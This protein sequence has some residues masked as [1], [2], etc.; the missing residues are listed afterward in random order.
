MRNLYKYIITLVAIL[1]MATPH[2]WAAATCHTVTKS[3]F[4]TTGE[5]ITTSKNW[6]GR[7]EK[8]YFYYFSPADQESFTINNDFGTI[9]NISFTATGD[10]KDD[11]LTF[12]VIYQ[13]ANNSTWTEIDNEIP[14][15]RYYDWGGWKASSTNISLSTS[16]Y[17]GLKD[18]TT[19]GIRFTKFNSS[20]NTEEEDEKR[21]IT[22]SNVSVTFSNYFHS[23]ANNT[24]LE[25][26][27][28]TEKGTTCTTTR[29]FT[30]KYNN[31]VTSVNWTS[32]NSM[33]TVSSSHEED[34]SGEKTV[35]ITFKPTEIRSEITGTITGTD[36]NGNKITVYVKGSSW[37]K[38]DPTY[39]WKPEIWDGTSQVR[40]IY[41][42]ET[43]NDMLNYTSSPADCT[44]TIEKLQDDG[45]NNGDATTTFTDNTLVAGR[46]GKYKLTVR[47]PAHSISATSGYNAGETTI[48]LTISK[49]E[50]S[51]DWALADTYWVDDQITEESIITNKT[52]N[53]VA[54]SVSDSQGFFTYSDNTLKANGNLMPSGESH[55]TTITVTQEE[56]YK[57]TKQTLTKQITLKRHTISAKINQTTAVWNEL[58]NNPFSASSTHP[59]SGQVTPIDD[60]TVT[61]QGNEHIALMD[62]NSRNIQTYYTNGTVYFLITHPEDY[63]YNALSQTLTLHV[64]QSEETCDLITDETA[65][66][67]HSTGQ[68]SNG[69]YSKIFTLNGI[70]DKLIFKY[71]LNGRA[72]YNHYVTP[73]YSTTDTG[74]N[75]N[76]ITTRFT[77]QSTTPTSS[78]SIT[79]PVGTKRIRF[80]RTAA[81]LGTKKV[82]LSNITVTRA[83]YIRPTEGERALSSTDT[84]KLP[85][86]AIGQPSSQQF[87]LKWSA[88]SD[89]KIVC[90]NPKFT[91]GT[92]DI[93]SANGNQ[94]IS[95]A[96]NTSEVGTFLGNITIYNQEQMETFPISC[97]V[98][99]KWLTDSIRGS[100]AYSMKVD[101]T[102][103]TD[104]Y[105]PVQRASQYPTTDGPFHYVIEHSNFVDADLADRNPNHR[106]EV[107]S[108]HNGVITAHNAGTAI[109]TIK[110]D[111]TAEHYASQQ[112][113][114]TLTVSKRTPVFTWN[115]PV[116]FNQTTISNYFTTNNTDTDIKIESQSDTDVAV[117]YFNPN[118]ANDKYTLDLTTYYKET[119][120]A[121]ST[122]V[123]VSQA[124]NYKW[125]D[126][127]ATHTITPKNENNH[128]QFTL[129]QENY[130]RDFQVE[131][132][133]PAANYKTPMG[134]DWQ[135]GGI[136]F[137]GAGALDENEG[138]NWDEK[139]IIIKFS[140]IPDKLTFDASRSS[141]AT[142]TIKLSVSEGTN[143]D[144]LTE[145]WS[146][147]NNS[148]NDSIECK[149]NPETRFL[150]FSYTGNLWGL[151]K[152]I[153][154]T[155]LNLFQADP[156]KLDFGRNQVDKQDHPQKPFALHYANAGYK[157]KLES[158]NPKFTIS[159]DEINSIGGEIYGTY[160]PITVTYNTDEEHITNNDGKII[161]TDEV[162]HYTEVELYGYTYKIPQS[163][164]WTENW[165]ANKPAMQLN[166]TATYVA[167]AT[168]TLPVTYTSSDETVIR[169]IENG[170]KLEALKEGTATI[171]A[172]QQGN[173]E[174]AA[175]ESISKEF[176][177]TSKIIQYVH[178]TDNLQRL[179]TTDE[180]ITLNAKIQLE[181][182]EGNRVDSPERTQLLKY[183]SLDENIV[184]INGNSLTIIGEG[185]TYVIAYETGDEKYEQVYLAMPVRVRK[186]SEGCEPIVLYQPD[187]I[188]FF[189]WNTNQ[190]IK[191]A[192][193]IDRSKGIPGYLSYQHKGERWLS[194]YTGTIKAQQ[195][196]DNGESWSDIEGSEVTPTVGTYNEKN[197]LLLSENATHIRFV[198][199]EG[200][201]G[202]HYI[203]DIVI[204]PAQYIRSDQGT[205]NF[206]EITV[207]SVETL[208]FKV[209]Y[210]NMQS[211]IRLT[212]SSTQL[213]LDHDIIVND[214]GSWGEEEFML[215]LKPTEVGDG[216]FQETITIYDEKANITHTIN[217]VAT[218]KKGGQQ[219][220]WEPLSDQLNE[221][222]DWRIDYTKNAYSSVHLPITYTMQE[223]EYARF[224]ANGNLVILKIGGTITI[225]AS[226]EGNNNFTAAESVSRTFNLPTE[227]TVSLTFIGGQS[228]N[229]WS[230]TLNWN[231]NRLPYEIEDITIKAAAELSSHA[232]VVGITL[233]TGTDEQ[234]GSIHI[235]STGGL[236]VGASGISG[237]NNNGSSIIIDNKP[238][239]A[240][241]L[242]ISPQAAEDKRHP[243]FTVNYTT[244]GYNK[245]VAREETWQYMGAPGNNASFKG[246]LTDKTMIYHWNETQGW[247]KQD[248]NSLTTIPTWQGYALTQSVEAN[249]TYQITA[250][251]LQ[252]THEINLTC[253]PSGMKGDNLFVN[254]F[255]APIDITKI[256][257]TNDE[258]SDIDDPNKKLWKIFYLFNAGSWNQWKGNGTHDMTDQEYDQSSAGHY[259][260][261]PI[262]S[263]KHTGD[264]Q[265][266]IPPMQGVYVYTEGPAT[267]KLDYAKHVWAG[268]MG[269]K[270]MRAPALDQKDFQR[271][272]IHIGSENSGADRMYIIQEASTTPEYDNGY[273]GDNINAKGQANIYTNEPFGKM[274]VSCSNNIDSMYIGITT[275]EDSIYTL[276][277]GAVQGDIYLKDL[278]NDSIFIMRDLQQYTFVATPNSTHDL[279]F[280]I[281]LHPQVNNGNNNGNSGTTTDITNI[282]TTHIWE[283]NNI[284]YIANAPI[285]SIAKIYTISGQVILTSIVPLTTHTIDVNHLQQGIYILQINNHMYKFVVE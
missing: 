96:C 51:F 280:Q 175:A 68:N 41:V 243:Y 161:I 151:F 80:K 267:I 224:D 221:S 153:T 107:I 219:I 93:S 184:S 185:E 15:E 60:F 45:I 169:V 46:A 232:T 118:D 236:T 206:G 117:L 246:G 33:F 9:S 256:I 172:S 165:Q 141:T 211:E 66:A 114:C 162:G 152:N 40:T 119:T 19:I 223:N 178:W 166:T 279:R 226:Q 193:E 135:D 262:H 59:V 233:A 53:E 225:T 237:A 149:L 91:I 253:T 128:V 144:N 134:P 74:D 199:P 228:D 263:A 257:E 261:I 7:E 148:T 81:T 202:Y 276:T 245:G 139:Y 94:E 222:N 27:P 14:L 48:I 274:E 204:T 44:Y 190:I 79:L 207:G 2:A 8:N 84:L 13:T 25:V 143:K 186:P 163:L 278:A 264:A 229:S 194:F 105:F 63:K 265:T 220:T 21:T 252:G 250:Q 120:P 259:Y 217:V 16:N 12:K 275:G 30:Y 270:P 22:I 106:D 61:Q 138:W 176:V 230:N 99:T 156:A 208:N 34:C 131:Y 179:L 29:S 205:I 108:Y 183:Y 133:D 111:E 260:T 100:E 180:P 214:C 1:T 269:N 132:V 285:N 35:T 198:R 273:D 75:F 126:T 76:D 112:F 6:L 136:Y 188:D 57:W 95:V 122:T 49:R 56:N 82:L 277:F 171:T 77:T 28:S 110:H 104:F 283:N 38:E 281:L 158:T 240:G 4:N 150:K 177:V 282:S 36:N 11:A 235:T 72:D 83:Q 113:T 255:A 239:G 146:N 86:V 127:T 174:W 154:V 54:I 89:I 123:T 137:G 71:Y 268:T 242:R 212:T 159:P 271:V 67:D 192:I 50:T 73:Q 155:E 209:L 272:R 218:V 124:E 97:E 85:T 88:C 181:D 65:N 195:S 47:Q 248:N 37:G 231:F 142:G 284:I 210:S 101:E 10:T 251:A 121:S 17:P 20:E 182:S 241:F 43:I 266:I 244:R 109:L 203:K 170:T 130:I 116:Y 160:A 247:V 64:N 98:Y 3:T 78:D 90:N 196:V 5:K 31:T 55:T 87:N 58:I 70:G 234:V 42:G 197:G 52:N 254:S 200:G 69:T 215:T 102:W 103:G 216:T 62:A 238:E 168:S 125:N 39:T 140:G 249:H 191:D 187:E 32:N 213:T 23:D 26:F 18:A 145:I 115:D 227:E 167:R 24:T 164:Y 129:T 147:S 173:D 258:T 189:Q 92:T 201:T 157:V